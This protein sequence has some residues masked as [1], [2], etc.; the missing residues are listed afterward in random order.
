[1]AT[2]VGGA[3]V[4]KNINSQMVATTPYSN[5]FHTLYP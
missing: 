2:V 5:F 4:N 3:K 1:M